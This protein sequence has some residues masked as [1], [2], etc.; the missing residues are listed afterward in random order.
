LAVTAS[1]SESCRE[2]SAAVRIPDMD[3]RGTPPQKAVLQ[4]SGLFLRTPFGEAQPIPDCNRPSG[5]P[6]AIG[7]QLSQSPL[8]VA[9]P[10]TLLLLGPQSA[11]ALPIVRTRS[12]TGQRASYPF[13]QRW[14]V[15][16][17]TPTGCLRETILGV[18]TRQV[19]GPLAT[20]LDR[21]YV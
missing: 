4:V 16:I 15:G 9:L 17:T 14:S 8:L 13:W 3:R 19:R 6:N 18:H 10:T 2:T 20:A 21:F 5:H 1:V 12:R 11:V 7:A